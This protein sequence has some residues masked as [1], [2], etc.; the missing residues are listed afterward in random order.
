MGLAVG[1]GSFLLPQPWQPRELHREE[2]PCRAPRVWLPSGLRLQEHRAAGS[3]PRPQGG[4]VCGSPLS[5]PLFT[6]EDPR[7][8]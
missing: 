4:L 6:A 8:S 7:P 3:G 2:E 5:R 1:S